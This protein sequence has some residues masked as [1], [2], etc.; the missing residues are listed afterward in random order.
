MIRSG[1]IEMTFHG[2]WTELYGERDYWPDGSFITTEWIVLAWIPIAPIC[3]KRVSLFQTSQYAQPD[4]SGFYVHET[5]APDSK[6]VL[7]VYGWLLLIYATIFSFEP[8]LPVVK[9]I[10]GDEDKVATIWLVAFA[11]ETAM[12]F[13]LR[14]VAKS[15]KAKEWERA[16]LGLGPPAL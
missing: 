1:A 3:S 14:R 12:P 7:C 15:R 16:K 9:K 10:I 11:A 4:S 8:L 6:Q 5:T 13:V 2:V